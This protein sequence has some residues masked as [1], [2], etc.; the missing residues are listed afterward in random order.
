MGN[1]HPGYPD[2]RFEWQN[3]RGAYTKLLWGK[4]SFEVE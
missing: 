3:P 4:R 2:L 1:T